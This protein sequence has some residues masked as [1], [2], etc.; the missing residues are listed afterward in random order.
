MALSRKFLAAMGIEA[1][2]IDEIIT[3]HVE[4]VDGLKK[5]RDDLKEKADKYDAEKKRE[6]LK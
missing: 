3:A 2:K 4:T 5:E 6:V 1:D